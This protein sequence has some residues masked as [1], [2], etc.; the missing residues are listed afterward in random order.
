MAAALKGQIE[1]GKV[2][3][4]ELRGKMTVKLKDKVLFPSGSATIGKQGRAALVAVAGVLA[5]AEGRLIRV[6][7]HT[8]DVRARKPYASNWEL[9]TARAVAVVRFLQAQGVD[10]ARLAAAGHGPYRPVAPNVTAT[11]R[12]Q[13]RRIEIVLAPVEDGPPARAGAAG[14]M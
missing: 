1:A 2:E 12:S 14:R 8:D 13:N 6:E 3:L 5:G 7:G 10:P 11:G 4:T 9:S